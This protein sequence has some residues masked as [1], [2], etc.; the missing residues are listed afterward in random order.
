M[1][2]VS[3]GEPSR[4]TP[5]ALES[6][7]SPR[8]IDTRPSVGAAESGTSR[9]KDRKRNAASSRPATLTTSGASFKTTTS[10]FSGVSVAAPHAIVVMAAAAKIALVPDSIFIFM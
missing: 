2:K 4:S 9:P 8:T 5:A 3:V 7:F 6:A 10:A 1:T